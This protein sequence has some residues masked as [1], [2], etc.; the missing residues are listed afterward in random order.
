MLAALPGSPGP[1]AIRGRHAAGGHGHPGLTLAIQD[2]S[3]WLV[4]VT[5]EPECMMSSESG[6]HG[7][8]PAA[9]AGPGPGGPADQ[10][11][12]SLSVRASGPG[13]ESR[14]TGTVQSPAA[15]LRPASGVN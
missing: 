10:R 5:G 13:T 4:T 3:S 14:V 8:G 6:G 11:W 15:R 2:D 7:E 9:A 12:L 1:P